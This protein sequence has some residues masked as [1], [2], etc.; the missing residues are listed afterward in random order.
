MNKSKTMTNAD[1]IIRFTQTAPLGELFVLLALQKF[2]EE[3]LKDPER[4][5]KKIP[6]WID[7]EA[8]LETARQWE[9]LFFQ[10]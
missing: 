5:G 9:K 4:I 10:Q 7:N 1:K 2:A 6:T 3:S 8:W